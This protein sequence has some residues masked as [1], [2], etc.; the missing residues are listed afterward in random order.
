MSDEEL[1]TKFKELAVD[2][3]R[4]SEEGDSEI[5]NLCV[6]E[7]G[8]VI[9]QLWKEHGQHKN[10]LQEIAKLSTSDHPAIAIK[11]ITYSLEFFP[12]VAE[13]LPK[14]KKDKSIIRIWATYTFKRLN[15]GEQKILKKLLGI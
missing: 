8:R 3:Y 12:E 11:A 7:I 2:H 6:D 13:G 1:L 4:A 5:A 9:R 10:A 15:N 14:L